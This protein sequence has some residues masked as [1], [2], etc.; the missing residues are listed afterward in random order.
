MPGFPNS[1][2]FVHFGSAPADNQ[3]SGDEDRSAFRKKQKSEGKERQLEK[4]K[5]NR[6][7]K[8]KQKSRKIFATN[9]PK[10]WL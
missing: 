5:T 6:C 2:M 8:G 3:M 10:Y 4:L 9:I 1:A 7:L